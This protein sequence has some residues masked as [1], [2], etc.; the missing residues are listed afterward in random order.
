[1][2]EPKSGASHPDVSV[3]R[4]LTMNLGQMLLVTGAMTIL[5][6]VTLSTN[7]SILQAYVI[8]YD[9]EATIDAVSIGEAMIDEIRTQAFDSVTTTTKK[10]TDPALCTPATRLGPDLDSEKTVIAFDTLPY[11]SQIM[12][13]D[14]D[15]YNGYSR[16]VKS[17]HLG[18]FTVRDSVF[19]VFETNLDSKSLSQT[20]YKRIV[21][22]I[23]HPNLYRPFVVKSLVVFRKY[24]PPS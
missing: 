19:Y 9:S 15:D 1:M 11:Q 18:I 17:P 22:T 23:N 5:A 24:L 3:A 21:V 2:R 12:F 16:I 14:V 8:S 4:V 7:S 13:N 6:M 10:I 20:W